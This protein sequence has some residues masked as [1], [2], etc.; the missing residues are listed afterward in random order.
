MDSENSNKTELA[1]L[2]NLILD[3]RSTDDDGAWYLMSTTN[4]NKQ[5]YQSTYQKDLQDVAS[6]LEKVYKQAHDDFELKALN[7]FKNEWGKY[8]IHLV[9]LFQFQLLLLL[10]PFPQL[11]L[12]GIQFFQKDRNL[13]IHADYKNFFVVA[14]ITFSS[15]VLF[16]RS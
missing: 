11:P 8:Q 12:L 2:N 14:A 10:L 9:D 5:K 1:E 15:F 16:L 6:E 3:V 4:E 7:S 13:T